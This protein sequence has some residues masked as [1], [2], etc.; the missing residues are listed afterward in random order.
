MFYF[1]GSGRAAQHAGLVLVLIATLGALTA[2]GN[3]DKAAGGSGQALVRVDGQEITV[4][5]LNDE[6]ARSNVPAAQR[7]A[8]S[9][10]LLADLVDRQLLDNAAMKDKIDRDPNVMAAIERAKAQI[11]AQ[12]YMQK[13]LNTVARPTK[14]EIDKYYAD[15][16]DF[17]A[18][19]KQYDLEQI[20]LHNKDFGADL[21]AMI[22]P[23]KSLDDIAAWLKDHHIEFSRSGFSRS[24]VDMVPA[25]TKKLKDMRKGQ[26]F[27]LQESG[28]NGAT[29]IAVIR[30]IK[31]DP[32]RVDVADTQIG[33]FLLNQRNRESAEAEVTRLRA[34]AKIEYLHKQPDAPAETGALN[35]SDSPAKPTVEEHTK[36]GVADL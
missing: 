18:E 21:K 32:A 36:R 23:N 14:E 4:H 3:K 12:A 34:Q 24:T 8:A 16:P 6:L 35:P 33:N 20:V 28:D 5:E 11:I 10:K 17:F 7:D 27:A 31:E 13:R 29:T 22:A 26:L 2:C 15:H 25:L 9:K 1:S 30:S 19:R